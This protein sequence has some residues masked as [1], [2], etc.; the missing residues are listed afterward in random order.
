M[1]ERDK[2]KK[3]DLFDYVMIMIGSLIM[4]V[5]LM[6]FLVPNKVSAGG[7]SGISTILYHMFNWPVGI[8]MLAMNVPLFIIGIRIFGRKFGMKTLWGIVWI[9]VFSD[10]IDVVLKLP[11]LTTNPLFATVYGG[12][13]L[14]RGLG[15]IMKGRGTTG[16]SDII[17]RILNKYF[18]FSLGISFMIIDTVI[19]LSMG[20]IFKNVELIL[21]CLIS[22]AISSKVVDMFI[23]G[24][25]SE[26]AITIMSKNWEI[27]SQRIMDEVNRGVTGLD[28]VGMH[29]NSEKKTLY[30]VVATRQIEHIRRIVKREDPFAFVTITN[31]SIMQG[32]GFR[33]RTTLNEE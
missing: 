6:L 18:H 24:L 8:S 21:F 19:I 20:I 11:S 23:E 2:I 5:G 33:E 28:S 1:S 7:V 4:A 12:L 22:L 25:T 31:V 13:L 27:I 15:I 14:G 30:C 29:T 32:E 10:L 3:N 26:R 17:A 16:G 9:S